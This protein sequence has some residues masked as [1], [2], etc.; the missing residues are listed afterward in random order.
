MQTL[1]QVK[2]LA[3]V[4]RFWNHVKTTAEPDEQLM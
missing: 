3:I 1:T 2:R 4:V